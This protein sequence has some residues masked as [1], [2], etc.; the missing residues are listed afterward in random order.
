MEGTPLSPSRDPENDFGR[1]K[2]KDKP[3]KFELEPNKGE[4]SLLQSRHIAREA[5]R[6]EETEV[7][8]S[9]EHRHRAPEAR[10]LHGGKDSP[11]RIG[12]VIVAAEAT[13]RKA[14]THEQVKLPDNKRIDTLTRPELLD[15]SQHVIV[16]GTSLR[17]VFETH[18]IGEHALRRLVGE[19][20]QGLDI[21]ASLQREIVEHEIDF[22][23]D[24]ALRDMTAA[25]DGDNRAS[26]QA[27]AAS[28]KE[29]LNQLLK[30]AGSGLFGSE[31]DEITYDHHKNPDHPRPP[32]GSNHVI[33][34]HPQSQ[35]PVDRILGVIIMV[36]VI[37][38]IVLY[39]WRR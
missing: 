12:H 33:E 39:F 7:R 26:D 27:D 17:Q 15:L 22:E 6:H 29:T 9:Y 31:T 35:R 34:A 3:K 8:Q 13:E 38:V 16:D 19:Y 21:R 25:S 30:K 20:F 24:P 36:L 32:Q 5:L 28:A 14:S 18:L 23:R 2:A 10:Q 37:L 11:E 4:L 1:K